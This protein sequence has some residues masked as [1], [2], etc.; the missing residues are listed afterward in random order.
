MLPTPSTSHV[1]L[2]RIYEPAEDS[3]LLL[4]TLSSTTETEFLKHRF[5]KVAGEI[6]PS[7]SPLVVEVG[8]GSGIVLAFIA[9]QA[10]AI[11][12][13]GDIVALGTDVNLFACRAAKQTVSQAYEDT[14]TSKHTATS[15]FP[16]ATLCASLISPLRYG[17]ADVLIFNPPYVPSPDTPRIR[18]ANS[19]DV[20][21]SHADDTEHDSHLLSLSYAG[22]LDGME[23][24]NK[25][26]KDLPSVMHRERGVAY[27]L[28]CQQNR[29]MEVVQR[30]RS[31]GNEWNVRIVGRSG[32]TAGWEKLV[33]IRIWRVRH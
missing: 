30:I 26:L 31:W 27:I 12:G 16:F 2:N 4:D 10:K 22:G 13:R 25:L 11:F 5:G 33:I 19:A 23:I 18:P 17:V 9:A 21:F 28:L 14:N 8:T 6:G 29:P 3:Y 7:P 20:A 1:D 32:K 24:T 15:A